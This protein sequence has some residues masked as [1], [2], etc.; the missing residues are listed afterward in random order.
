MTEFIFENEEDLSQLPTRLL[1]TWATIDGWSFKRRSGVLHFESREKQSVKTLQEQVA[2][3]RD[4]IKALITANQER[5][6]IESRQKQ[7]VKTL[8]D[9]FKELGDII[10]ALI[11]ANG[12][13]LPEPPTH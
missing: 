10:T 11:A 4:T 12:L 7:S 6:N 9:Q 5:N 13:I 1:N 2:E 8:Q 3:L